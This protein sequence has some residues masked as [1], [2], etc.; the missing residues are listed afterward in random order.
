M[1]VRLLKGKKKYIYEIPKDINELNI[2]RYV[3]LKKLTEEIEKDTE[4]NKVLKVLNCISNIPKKEIYN[5]DLESLGKIIVHINKFL[6]T[7]PNT[8]V[9]EII[10]IEGV[11]YGL[12]PELEN[13]DLGAFVDLET[14]IKDVDE[15]IHKIFSVL[16][17]PV[18]KQEG[19]KYIIEEYEPN[20]ERQDLFR[21]KL[22]IQDIYG[23]WVFFYNLDKK[24]IDTLNKSSVKVKKYKN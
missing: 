5:L 18:K 4:I 13:M 8:E 10:E 24:R 2:S 9:N 20:K 11:K 1:K 23:A 16:Y 21:K 14:Y 19:K 7:T 3:R 15:N 12:Q 22:T 17:R 6:S